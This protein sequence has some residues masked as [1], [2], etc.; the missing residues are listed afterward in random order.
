[1][2]IELNG[3]KM[4]VPICSCG[5][6]IIRRDRFGNR[7]TKYP[8]NK[9]M[10]ST[11]N[12]THDL[13]GKGLS[14]QF[15]NRSIRNG[16]EGSYKEH[17]TAGLMSTMKFDFK[18]FLV[19][20]DTSRLENQNLEQTPFF[21]KST[22]SA[23]FPSWGGASC[24]NG[25]KEKLPFI[26]VPFRGNSNYLENHR[27]FDE[28][29]YRYL[30]PNLKQISSLGFKGKILNDSNVK[31]SYKPFESEKTYYLSLERPKKFDKE[32]AV[33]IPADYPKSDN[34]SSTYGVNFRNNLNTECELAQFLK[35]SGMKN[36]EL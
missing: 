5:K 28:D 18:P 25:P 21:G 6:C 16:F 17:L 1:M 20:L 35:R 19:K 12:K 32:K 15:F 3:E 23:N 22:Y 33:I 9:T 24:G 27:K 4:T 11:Y 30:S 10:G 36:L 8:Y 31:E 7:G 2:N 26:N 14:A 13:K 29:N 34:L